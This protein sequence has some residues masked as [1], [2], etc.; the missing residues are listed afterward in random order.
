MD[1]LKLQ[2]MT[3]L[4][5]QLASTYK[6]IRELQPIINQITSATRPEPGLVE[7]AFGHLKN[8]GGNLGD[9]L[10][11]KVNFGKFL[12][13]H[14]TKG[15]NMVKDAVNVITGIFGI[16][17]FTTEE[18]YNNEEFQRNQN[19][20]AAEFNNIVQGFEEAKGQIMNNL[21]EIASDMKSQIEMSISENQQSLVNNTDSKLFKDQYVK[22]L[23]NLN[24][25]MANL[26]QRKG[27]TTEITLNNA[28]DTLKRGMKVINKSLNSN[29]DISQDDQ[30]LRT[31]DVFRK[32]NNE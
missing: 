20:V 25:Q 26:E 9:L 15:F 7:K 19:I 14:F 2:N 5:N 10:S 22:K 30:L 3:K 32:E 24:D 12:G 29:A 18:D 11:G 1:N 23:N 17:A 31:S 8:L 21:S 27:K 28:Q 16:K 6:T 13:N 4:N